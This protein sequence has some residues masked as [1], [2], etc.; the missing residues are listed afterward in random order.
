MKAELSRAEIREMGHM[1][2]QEQNALARG[3]C[4]YKSIKDSA[5]VH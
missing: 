5:Y 3:N 1:T 2:L 4:I